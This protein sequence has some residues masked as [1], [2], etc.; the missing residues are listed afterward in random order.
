MLNILRHKQDTG[1]LPME[2]REG[3]AIPPDKPNKDEQRI[4]SGK[5]QKTFKESDSRTEEVPY[6]HKHLTLA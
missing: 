4:G 6:N 5:V 1:R 3:E 2:C